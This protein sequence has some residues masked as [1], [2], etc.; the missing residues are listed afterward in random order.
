MIGDK[1]R[2]RAVDGYAYGDEDGPDD[3]DHDRFVEGLPALAARA[4]EA[5]RDW[6]AREFTG[7]AADGQV[8]ATVDAFGTLRG[9]EIHVLARRRLDNVTLGEAIVAAVRA[10]ESA[11]ATAHRDLLGTLR[12]PGPGPALADLLAA[13]PGPARTGTWLRSPGRGTGRETA[14]VPPDEP[15]HALP[16]RP[17]VVPDG[18]AGQERPPV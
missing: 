13:G 6:A 15:V 17:G 18:A 16:A 4:A 14:T 10:A 12:P 3:A 5:A 9:L 7:P 1:G 2:G 11:A 8:V